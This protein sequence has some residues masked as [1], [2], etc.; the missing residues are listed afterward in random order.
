[1]NRITAILLSIFVLL[2]AAHPA[3]LLHFCSGDLASVSI[4]KSQTTPECCSD[5]QNQDEVLIQMDDDCCQNYTIELSTDDY[6]PQS[7]I[8]QID[9]QGFHHLACLYAFVIVFGGVTESH[10]PSEYK[11]RH[12]ILYKTGRDVLSRFCVYII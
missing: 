1:M 2:L 4:M 5:E 12:P 11:D 9:L 7:S 10:L 6:T 8:S 3:V